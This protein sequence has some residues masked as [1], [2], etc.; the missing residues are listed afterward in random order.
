MGFIWLLILLMLSPLILMLVGFILL[1]NKDTATR[2]RGRNLLLVGLI[3]LLIEIL[4]GY[5]VCSN[6]SFH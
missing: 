4:I 6:L 2:K 3:L 5:S 1:L